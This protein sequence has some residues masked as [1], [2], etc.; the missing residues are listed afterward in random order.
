MELVQAIHATGTPVVIVI[1]NGKPLNNEWITK[2]IPT[3]VDVWEPGMYGGQALAEILFG[4]VNPSGK[5]PNMP[6]KSQCIIIKDLP[7]IGRV[8]VWVLPEKMKNL[9]FVSVMD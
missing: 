3:I 9:H 6:V 8:M 1:V 7:D 4:E 2:N 5:L